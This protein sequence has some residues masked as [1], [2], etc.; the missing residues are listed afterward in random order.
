MCD[1]SG[2]NGRILKIFAYLKSG[3]HFLP[4]CKFSETYIYYYILSNSGV[5][6]HIIHITFDF[7]MM[8]NMTSGNCSMCGLTFIHNNV[9]GCVTNIPA[10]F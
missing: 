4:G 1:N 2:N 3:G 5:H 8:K 10:N 6:M 7:N 9:W